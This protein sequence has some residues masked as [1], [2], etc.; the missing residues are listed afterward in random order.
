MRKHR[1]HTRPGRKLLAIRTY[2]RVWAA[3]SQTPCAP[4]PTLA[5]QLRLSTSTVFRATQA[6]RD[7]GYITFGHGDVN[8]RTVVVPFVITKKAKQ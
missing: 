3:L 8:A 1:P 7:A 2:R 5:R 4:Y 6:L